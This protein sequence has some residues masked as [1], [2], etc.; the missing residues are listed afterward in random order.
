VERIA[1]LEC[2]NRIG[3]RRSLGDIE[4]E[5]MQVFMRPTSPR[6]K[7]AAS[8]LSYHQH[9]LEPADVEIVGRVDERKSTVAELHP[10]CTIDGGRLWIIPSQFRSH[11]LNT[12]FS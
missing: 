2:D 8:V 10:S 4:H 9:P 6:G 3:P 1:I 11:R 7:A 12:T 5:S